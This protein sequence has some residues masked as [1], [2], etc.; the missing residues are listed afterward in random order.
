MEQLISLCPLLGVISG[1]NDG[2]IL[3]KKREWHKLMI[4]IDFTAGHSFGLGRECCSTCLLSQLQDSFKREPL[5]T[6][7]RGY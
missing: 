6:I 1:V 5:C 2:H 7:K 4:G 3:T